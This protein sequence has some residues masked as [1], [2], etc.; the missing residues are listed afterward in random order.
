MKRID[1]RSPVLPAV[2][3]FTSLVLAALLS[4]GAARAAEVTATISGT[5]TDSTGAVMPKVPVTLT[6]TGTNVSRT[7]LT[8]N[9]GSYLFTLVPIGTYRVTA[10]R[11]GFRR[12]VRE[13][14][15]LSVNQ[16]AKLDISLQVGQVKDVIEVTENV[17]QVDTIGAMLGSV[18]T[19]RRI[20]DL[21]LVERDTF[22]LGLLQ[23]GV[24]P[25]D[26]DDGSGNPFSVSG[27]RS[28]SLSFLINGTDNNDFLGNNAVV[29]PNPDAVAEFKILTNNYTAEFGRT[30]GGIVNQVIKSGT[31][32]YHGD[33]FEFF[34][35]EVLNAR[36]YFLPSVTPFKRNTF[37]GTIGGPIRKDKTF[38]FFSYQGVR[39]REGEIAPIL[40][41]LSPAERGCTSP[42]PGCVGTVADFSELLPQ[43]QLVNPIT[44][45]NYA[46]NQVPIDPV[47]QNYIAKFLP[48]PNIPGTNNFISSPVAQIRD[49]QG[50]ARIDHHIGQDDIIYGSYVIDDLSQSF[51]FRILNGASTGGN[52]P[53]GSG[54]DTP[55]RTQLGAISWLHNFNPRVVN[56]F[57]FG[58]NRSAT[59]QAVP[60]DHTPPS[61]LGFTNVNPDDPAGTAPPVMT[62]TTFNLGP[63]P[64]GPT[65]LRDVTFHWQDNLS[66][67]RGHHG[68]KFGADIRRVR[69]NFN[70]DFDNNGV[71]DFGNFVSPFTGDVRADFAGGFFD[72]YSQFS[73]AVYGIRTTSWHF[74]G[75]DSWKVLPRLTVSYGLRYEYN[76]PLEDPHNEIL[77]FFTPSSQQEV[78]LSPSCTSFQSAKFPGAPPGVLYPGD[79]GTPNRGLTFPDRNNFAPRFGFAWDVMGNAKLVVRGGFGIFYD[80]EDGALNLQFGGQAPF[81]F[82]TG[83]NPGSYSNVTPGFDTIADPF[84]PFNQTNPYPSAGKP[85]SFTVPAISFAF[86]LDP[87]FR[88]PYSENFNFGLQYQLTPDTL[89]EANYVSSLSRKSIVTADVNPPLP[90]I[91][92][93]QFSNAGSTFADCARPLAGC[94]DPTNPNDPNSSPTVAGQMLVDLSAGSSDSHQFQLTV[95]KRF[96]HGFNLRGAY[97]LAKT[98]DTQS[99]FRY[100]SSLFTDP[101]NFAFDRGL[102][103]FDVRHRVVISGIWE[104]PFDRPFRGGH[105]FVRKMTEGWQVSGI[106][107]FQ[108]GTPFTIFSNDDQSHEGTGLDRADLIGP[109]HK[110]NPRSLHSFDPSTANCLGQAVSNGNFYFDPT[111]YNCI[112]PDFTFGNSG[113]NTIRGPGRNNFDLTIGRRFKLGEARSLEFRSEFFNAFNHAQFFNPDHFGFSNTFGQITQARDPRIIQFALKFYY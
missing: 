47:I 11:A 48:L 105:G 104:L 86:V 5:V 94:S 29:D 103:N 34:R 58:A 63:S 12:Y 89:V 26:E 46:N 19:S 83:I 49:D 78:C 53:V 84:T 72:S 22:Q 85:L 1:D 106:A 3:R 102:A 44:G 70:F 57:I 21:P 68:L 8:E 33:I 36:N 43:T 79:P 90:S 32:Q 39:K 17:T 13:G 65:T 108:S 91:L 7:I 41:V 45:A 38:F 80:I 112:P 111:A 4:C 61:A 54:F 76:T 18:E 97:T 71:F 20:V 109:I 24:F 50:I 56:E 62:T 66:V 100:T 40:Q 81:G 16:N 23:A 42:T 82:V 110:F 28:E 67:T 14:I 99:G 101:F 31:N 75:Q 73:K 92:M 96:S 95:D 69:N 74:F 87:H 64:Q 25:P 37:G 98:I 51:P 6:N 107:S 52:V 30:A 27:Q 35:N 2:F 88:T 77:G 60:H 59:L 9:D 93:Q 55:I 10:E 15:V 113:R